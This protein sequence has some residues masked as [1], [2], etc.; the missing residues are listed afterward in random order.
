MIMLAIVEEIDYDVLK[1]RET[2]F[3]LKKIGTCPGFPY[4]SI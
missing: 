2:S 4:A 3:L 1:H